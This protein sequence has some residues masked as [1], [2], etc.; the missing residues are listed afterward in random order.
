MEKILLVRGAAGANWGVPDKRRHRGPDPEDA[1]LFAPEA[2]GVMRQAAGDLC[3]LLNHGYTLRSAQELVGNR[4]ELVRRQRIAV[5]R[6]VCSDAALLRRQQHEVKP[7]QIRNG[8]LWLDGYNILNILES[9]M[10]GGV[11]LLG[12]DGC[13][14]DMAGTH[15]GYHL[16]EETMPSLRMLGE[17]LA[18]LEIA[19]CRWWLDS[20]VSN[21]GRLKRVLLDLAARMG[22]LWQ[23]ELVF[24]PDKVLSETPHIA[25]SSDS[26]I[27]DRCSHWMNLARWIVDSKMPEAHIVDLSCFG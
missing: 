7:A 3:W 23:V 17:S 18:T 11:I 5:A 2:C 10:A 8:E 6:C 25:A 13:Y 12:R 22:W 4:Y 26:V 27:L 21:S 20:P 14:R 19:T 16:V 15:G 9:A 1:R 24:S